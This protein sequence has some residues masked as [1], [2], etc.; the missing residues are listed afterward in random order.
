MKKIDIFL[1]WIVA[2]FLSITIILL[3]IEIDTYF[4][5]DKKTEGDF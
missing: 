5:T 2:A 3:L 4:T 1:S